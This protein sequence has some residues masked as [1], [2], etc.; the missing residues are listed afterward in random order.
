MPRERHRLTFMLLAFALALRMLV[1]V[2]WMP[3]AGGGAFAIEPCPSLD[4]PP[5]MSMA[6]HRH[7]TGHHS[8]P[9]H[10]DGDCAFAPMMSAFAATDPAAMPVAPGLAAASTHDL[11]AELF[12]AT[13]PPA[14]P[15]PAT[16]PPATA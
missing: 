14:L 16:G 6:G 4:A 3:A 11:P 13:G 8:H 10:H 12:F 2:G 5:M 1:P 9:A 7:D 15:P